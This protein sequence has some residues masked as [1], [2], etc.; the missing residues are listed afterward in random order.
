MLKKMSQTYENMS[1]S[2]KEKFKKAMAK[3]AERYGQMSSEEKTRFKAQMIKKI[4]GN[5]G[6]IR[7]ELKAK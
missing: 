4:S 5:G 2:Q 1:D 3:S 7:I 6:P